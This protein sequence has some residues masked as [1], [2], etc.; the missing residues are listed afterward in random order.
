MPMELILFSFTLND[1]RVWHNEVISE[2]LSQKEQ[3][4][5]AKA[6]EEFITPG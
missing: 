5:E 2:A 3:A 6:K 4:I 1:L